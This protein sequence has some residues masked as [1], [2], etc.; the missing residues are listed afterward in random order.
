MRYRHISLF[1]RR[2]PAS[3]IAWLLMTGEW[4]K[5]PIDHRNNDSTDD[6]WQ[7]LRL[8]TQAQNIANASI[9]STN[10]SGYKG[11][12]PHKGNRWV[13]Q[14]RT[15]AGKKHLGVFPTAEEAARAYDAKAVELHG[16]FA[17]LNF[18]PA[19]RP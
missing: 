3:H 13:A 17:Y 18:L 14:I 15:P 2:Y 6:R 4:P 11:V 7:N 12:Y 5:M 10:T 16:E 8:A 19:R 1:G 9:R